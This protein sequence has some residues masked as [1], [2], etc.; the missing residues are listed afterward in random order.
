MKIGDM[1]R[2]KPYVKGLDRLIGIIVDFDKGSGKFPIVLW[3]RSRTN[4]YKL[5]P[6]A[7]MPDLIEV[8]K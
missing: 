8:V 6:E 2:Y 7:E 1:V 5:K 4:G 3:N